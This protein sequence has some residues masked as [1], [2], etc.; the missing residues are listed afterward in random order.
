MTSTQVP[1]DF[2]LS[3]IEIP[4]TVHYTT[5]DTIATAENSRKTISKLKNVVYVQSIS[6]I[7]FN[8]L[9]FQLSVNAAPLVFSKILKYFEKY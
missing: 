6:A 9:D 4:L 1:P 3:R 8:H 7:E 2:Q 5:H